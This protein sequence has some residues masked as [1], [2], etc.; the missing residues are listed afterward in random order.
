MKYGE[1]VWAAVKTYLGELTV[2]AAA[3]V[4]AKYTGVPAAAGIEV[5][6]TTTTFAILQSIRLDRGPSGPL[7][8]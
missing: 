8:P 5:F 1:N 3:P 6:T 2:P 4:I 7:H